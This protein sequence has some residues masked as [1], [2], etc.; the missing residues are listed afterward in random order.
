MSLAD[1]PHRRRNLLSGKWLLA[2]PPPRGRDWASDFVPQ[3][4]VREDH[5]QRALASR[6]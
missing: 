5:Q 1:H 2:T 6:S 3:L 4:V